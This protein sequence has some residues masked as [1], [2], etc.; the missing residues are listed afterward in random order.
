MMLFPSSYLQ[1]STTLLIDR[2]CL[3][4]LPF[5]AGNIFVVHIFLGKVRIKIIIVKMCPVR[6]DLIESGCLGK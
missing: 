1:L 5:H 2:Q 6:H 3:N 4:Y